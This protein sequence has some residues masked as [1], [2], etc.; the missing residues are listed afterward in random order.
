MTS[1]T[2]IRLV[3][4]VA[5][6]AALAWAAPCRAK[7]SLAE[8]TVG[9]MSTKL[10]RGLVNVVTAPAEWPKQMYRCTRDEGAVG[11]P[12]GFFK[13]LGMLVYR[14][15]FGA[16]EAVTFLVPA[17]GCYDPLTDP[18]YVWQGWSETTGGTHACR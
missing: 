8:D 14:A 10:L 4:A 12:I 16:V 5:G 2:R 9:R 18:A 11:V 1:T 3:L 15:G 7:D 6:F 13:G 17:P